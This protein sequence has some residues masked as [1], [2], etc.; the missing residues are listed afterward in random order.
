MRLPVKVIPSLGQRIGRV[1]GNIVSMLIGVAMLINFAGP[2]HERSAW[3]FVAVAAALF[4]TGLGGATVGLIN[5]FGGSPFQHLIIDRQGITVRKIWRPQRFSWKDLGPFHTYRSSIRPRNSGPRYAIAA[6]A[7][8][9][10]QGGTAGFW[11]LSRSAT[12]RIPA[13]TYLRTPW[14]VIGSME[15][16]ADDAVAWLEQLRQLAL[17]DRLA[18]EE[19]RDW[20]FAVVLPLTDEGQAAG[21]GQSHAA[22]ST[23]NTFG[24]R[25]KPVVE[26]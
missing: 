9:T 10:I 23:D 13:A 2:G 16:F 24:K 26:R 14:L 17:M 7:I 1:I 6:E 19:L 20:P 18:E 4:L 22:D 25:R 21:P 11:P 15:P 8:G 12:L 3:Y 5:V